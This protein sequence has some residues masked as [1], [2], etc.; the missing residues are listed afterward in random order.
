MAVKSLIVLRAAREASALKPSRTIWQIQSF[1]YTSVQTMKSVL[2]GLS[3]MTE[4][5]LVQDPLSAKPFK[6]YTRQ[7]TKRT[8]RTSLVSTTHHGL[9][10]MQQHL[11]HQ[12]FQLA[13]TMFLLK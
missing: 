9:S 4:L 1:R 5:V 8:K 10:G 3:P 2:L 6:H 7:R 11:L 12:F 13:P